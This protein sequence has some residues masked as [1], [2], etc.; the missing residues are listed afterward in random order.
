MAELFEKRVGGN[1]IKEKL[2]ESF[3][4]SLIGA[5]VGVENY[6]EIMSNFIRNRSL[7]DSN[8]VRLVKI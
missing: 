5:R 2:K 3:A 4:P 6:V 1:L 8:L 7:F